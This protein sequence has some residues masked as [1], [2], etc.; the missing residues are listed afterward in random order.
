MSVFVSSAN[1]SHLVEVS[2]SCSAVRM[3]SSKCQSSVSQ[4]ILFSYLLDPLLLKL[5]HYF[6]KYSHSSD[7][8]A[9][10]LSWSSIEK[11]SK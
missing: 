5:L 2:K 3:L 8:V 1:L 7:F 6:T 4:Y 10:F 11:V 9:Y